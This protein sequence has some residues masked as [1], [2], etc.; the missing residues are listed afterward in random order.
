MR[1]MGI[2]IIYFMLAN[3]QTNAISR[4]LST[5]FLKTCPPRLFFLV[6]PPRGV[7]KHSPP[8]GTH[9]RLEVTPPP[10]SSAEAATVV[11]AVQQHMELRLF[12]DIL[13]GGNA[14]VFLAEFFYFLVLDMLKSHAS[15]VFL[16]G[17]KVQVRAFL[18]GLDKTVF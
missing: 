4:P 14:K 3:E 7:K 6:P 15:S 9:F 8:W 16:I 18:H 5:N 2:S 13:S 12:T 10:P 1:F 17:F 11:Q